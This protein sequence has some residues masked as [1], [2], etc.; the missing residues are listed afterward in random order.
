MK[1]LLLNLV[2]MMH[3][4]KTAIY[5]F[6][7]MRPRY[8]FKHKDKYHVNILKNHILCYKHF[9]SHSPKTKCPKCKVK[10]SI[11]C[12]DYDDDK[13][14]EITASYNFPKLRPLK[15]LKH[16]KKGM[17]NI[18][19]NHILCKIHDISHG[20]ETECKK[21][22]LDI[23]NYDTSSKHMQDKI[24]KN[25]HNNLIEKIK[26]K[27]TNH[28][29]KEIYTN[30]LNNSTDKKII[31]LKLIENERDRLSSVKELKLKSHDYP[32]KSEVN[33]LYKKTIELNMTIRKIYNRFKETNYKY[34]NDYIENK[35]NIDTMEYKILKKKIN[36]TYLK[37]KEIIKNRKEAEN[38]KYKED[39][40]KSKLEEDLKEKER[41][42]EYNKN[43]EKMKTYNKEVLRHDEN[44]NE[45]RYTCSVCKLEN[46]YSLHWTK[47]QFVMKKHFKLELHRD[48][49]NKKISIKINKSI[50]GKFVDIIFDF[51]D[52]I[53]TTIYE[54]LYLKKL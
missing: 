37:I 20:K 10:K 28:D 46:D 36:S 47:Q 41:L 29:L 9:I 16:R 5:N 48:N 45:A 18:K 14:C 54:D 38:K 51:K 1:T 19:R 6:W 52:L 25:F 2:I 53:T 11:K 7:G 31:K 4:K 49:F 30:I 32:I 34:I 44:S 15:C 8:C 27:F 26:K 13:K 12:D 42:E 50:E 24:F 33:Y 40:E 35:F 17:V 39:L 23:D 43:Q 21:C 3:V 22:K